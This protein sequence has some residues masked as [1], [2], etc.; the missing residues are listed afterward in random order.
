MIK[1]TLSKD[2]NRNHYFFNIGAHMSLLIAEKLTKSYG[3]KALF[4]DISFTVEPQDKIGLVGVNGTGKSTL[5]KVL[6][7]IDS[8]DTG[9]I[10]MGKNIRVEYL[11]QMPDFNPEETILEHVLRGDSEIMR[12]I[13]S[14]ERLLEASTEDP[15]NEK[16]QEELMVMTDEMTRLEAWT[17]ESE[18][19]TVLTKLGITKFNHSV[20]TLSGGQKKRVALSR[21]LITP[22]DLLILDEPTN[23]MDSDTIDWLEEYL[24]SRKGALLMVTHDRYFLDRVTNRMI[25]LSQGS[26]YNYQGNYTDY[27][28]KKTER[29]EMQA[30]ILKKNKNLYRTELAWIRAGVQGRGTKQRARIQR[31]DELKSSL[32]VDQQDTMSISIPHTRLGKKIVEIKS[33]EMGFDTLKLINDFTYTATK[34]DRIGVVGDNGMGKTTLLKLIIGTL[35]PTAGSIDLGD[36]VKIGYYSQ[37]ADELDQNMTALAAVKEVAEYATTEDGTKLSAAQMMERFLFPTDLQWTLVRK[38]SGGEKRRLN[39]LR[40]LML[41]PN[42]LILDEPT[43]D[44][45]LETLQ[46]L[47]DYLDHFSGTVMI[48]SHDRYFLDRTCNKIFAFEGNASIFEYV[49]NYSEYRDFRKHTPLDG[50][51]TETPAKKKSGNQKDKQKKLKMTFKEEHEYKTIYDEIEELENKISSIDNDM[52][53]HA[54]NFGKLNELTKEKDQLEEVLLEKMERL[55]Y[56][57]DLKERIEQQ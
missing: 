37:D 46:I 55:E 22:C 54:T 16:I 9:E 57:E 47:E 7:G 39:L 48:V 43:N 8:P 5:L 18:I 10:S 52:L 33:L 24:A 1:W 45:D 44:L 14:Y 2:K 12:T 13:R 3:E 11:E 23:H 40:T 35:Q 38:L 36:T 26:L 34:D 19:K 53:L 56:L 17:F 51:L 4:K 27:L 29:Q 31:F 15:T 25:E 6:A 30:S 49:G 42:L 50:L 41:A 20:K 32:Q 21:V 28:E